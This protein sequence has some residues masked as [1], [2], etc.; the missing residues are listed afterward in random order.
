M[1]SDS[2][3]V[4]EIPNTIKNPSKESK[5][6]ASEIKLKARKPDLSAQLGT[7]IFVPHR[8]LKEQNKK[9]TSLN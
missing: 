5:F 3:P 2:N 4:Q 8:H 6:T 9:E 7:K 1:D